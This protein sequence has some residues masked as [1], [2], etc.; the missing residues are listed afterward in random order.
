MPRFAKLK[1]RAVPEVYS[2]VVGELKWGHALLAYGKAG[3]W[4]VC[5]FGARDNA[6]I[7]AKSPSKPF[8][9]QVISTVELADLRAVGKSPQE[10]EPGATLAV[11]GNRQVTVEDQIKTLA[12]MA[13]N[14]DVDDAEL[15][16]LGDQ[17]NEPTLAVEPVDDESLIGGASLATGGT[18]P[19]G[20]S[21]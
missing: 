4:L 7:L 21:G 10:V 15:A 9:Q 11:S 3:H 2:A 6:W 19:P 18:P 5:A 20:T 17:S 12:A 1:V 13:E 14:A 16:A 8:L